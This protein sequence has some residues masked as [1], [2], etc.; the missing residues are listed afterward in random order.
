MA[1]VSTNPRGLLLSQMIPQ[2]RWLDQGDIHDE[3]RISSCCVEPERCQP[4][5][6]FV[7]LDQQPSAAQQA[8]DTA[9]RRGA[10][11]VLGDRIFCQSVRQFLVEDS[12]SAYGQLCHA[13]LDHPTQSMRTV[14]IS[15]S[16]GKTITKHLLMGVFQAAHCQAGAV[17]PCSPRSRSGTKDLRGPARL[18][19]MLAQLRGR[20]GTHAVIDASCKALRDQQFS[21]LGLD[22]AIVTNTGTHPFAGRTPSAHH[23]RTTEQLLQHL[24]PGGFAVLSADDPQNTELLSQLEIPVLTVGLQQPA[25]LTATLLER[26]PS[27]QT[28]LLEAGDESYAVRTAIIGDEHVSHCL[29]TAAVALGMGLAP[30]DIVRGLESVQ[31][32]PG[33]LQRVECGQP[34]SV[35]VD[36]CYRPTD[37]ARTLRTL[38]GVCSGRLFCLAGID[39]RLPPPRRAAVGR[40]LERFADRSVLTGTRLHRKL[41][42]RT[43]HDVLDGFDRPAQA[44][45]MPNRSRALCWILSQAA[46][47][48]V[49]LL[50][51]GRESLGPEE[52]VL[53]DEDVARYWLP[54]LDGGEICPW[55]PA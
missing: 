4:G 39:L 15:G 51:G 24:K 25:D 22:A 16:H 9:V 43:A 49:L 29:A 14:G 54:Q 23:R 19:T 11:A 35:Y 52:V 50:A 18:A 41:P 31:S 1:H 28:F 46:P 10:G 32:V 53:Q 33:H 2:G 13:L 17:G 34:F 20:G 8:V 12:R 5:D 30:A 3:I 44:H 45:L 55:N 6:L 36:R 7:A 38:R 37:L 27:E 26:H 47:G 48:D 42:M 40:I 21:G